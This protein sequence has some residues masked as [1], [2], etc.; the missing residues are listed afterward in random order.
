LFL[1]RCA[2]SSMGFS[3]RLL[4]F[5]TAG[6]LTGIRLVLIWPNIGLLFCPFH[7][8]INNIIFCTSIAL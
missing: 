1:P 3:V 8:M 6:Q 2:Y 7:I 5:L 4:I